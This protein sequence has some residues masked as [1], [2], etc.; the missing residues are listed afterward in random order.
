[1][2]MTTELIPALSDNYIYLIHNNSEALVVDPAQ[3]APVRAALQERGL[4]LTHILNTHHHADHIDGNQE[5][6]KETNC[7]LWAPEDKRIAGADHLLIPNTEVVIGPLTF[8]VIAVP[9]HTSTHIALYSKDIESVFCGDSLFTGGCG[10]L[11]E[12]SA[13]QM[14]E[15]LQRLMHLPDATRVYCGHEYTESNLCFALTVDPN[16]GK[17]QQ[18]Y[19]MVQETRKAGRPTIP[20]TI[21]EEKQTNPFLRVA[22]QQLRQE[23]GMEQASDEEVFAKLRALKD[24]F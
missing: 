7:Q 17:L 10:R 20:S 24:H 9:G 22:K 5:L 2:T 18:R 11:F 8:T 4:K 16:N 3:A 12:G 1:M 19:Q 13:A 15:S 6:V 21:G 23:L 14:W